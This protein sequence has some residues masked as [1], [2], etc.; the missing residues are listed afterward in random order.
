[1]DHFIIAQAVGFTGYLIFSMAARFKKR[2]HILLCEF[3][4]CAITAFQWF[5]LDQFVAILIDSITAYTA[6]LG[7]ISI[8]YSFCLPLQKL[9]YVMLAAAAV[10][11]FDGS[12]TYYVAMALSVTILSAKFFR[13][14]TKLRIAS[15]LVGV[16]WMTFA[17][18][19]GSIPSFFFAIIYTYGHA[20]ELRLLYKASSK[21]GP[22]MNFR[23]LSKPE[24]VLLIS[25]H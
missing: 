11:A 24:P 7:A 4:G 10:I 9:C 3:L 12:A 6:L 8:R 5:L 19:A 20:Y 16:I 15:L 2:E 23:R 13:D 1:M 14:V 25:H 22:M 17:V 21:Y 18:L